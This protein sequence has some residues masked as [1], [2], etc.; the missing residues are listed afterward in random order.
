M[1][2][3]GT[4]T[5]PIGQRDGDDRTEHDSSGSTQASSRIW[6]IALILTPLL[7]YGCWR[8][9]FLD[10]DDRLFILDNPALKLDAP[11][12]ETF[13]R[14]IDYLYMPLTYLSLRIDHAISA[15]FAG[16]M[17]AA[18]AWAMEIRFGNVLIHAGAALMAWWLMRGLKASAPLA[19][20]VA[21][22]F[23]LHPTVCHS[24]CWP[25]QRKTVLAAF[26]GYAA[27]GVYVRGTSARHVA[28]AALLHALAVLS[29][30]SA[31]GLLPAI[32]VWE[33]LGRPDLDAS[34]PRLP[35]LS[36]GFADW[37]GAALR[38]SPWVLTLAAAYWNQITV[39]RSMSTSAPPLV[40]GSYWTV[41]L[42]DVP[43][44]LRYVVNF[45]WPLHLSAEYGLPAVVSVF[46]TEL[47]L[48]GLALGAFVALTFFLARPERRRMMVFAWLAFLALLFPALNFFGKYNL[49]ADCHAYLSTPAFWLVVGLAAEGAAARMP[50]LIPQP[51]RAAA[52]AVAVLSVA[53]AAGSASRSTV[54]AS[55]EAMYTDCAQ[56][57]PRCAVGRM[58]L[59][60]I[61]H[62]KAQRQFAA[63]DL[64]GEKISRRRELEELEACVNGYLFE[65]CRMTDVYLSLARAYYEYGR[66]DEAS[67]NLQL[68]RNSWQGMDRNQGSL[69]MWLAG[70]INADKGDFIKAYRDFDGA[71]ALAPQN[72]FIWLDRTKA[73]LALGEKFQKSGENESAK[74]SFEAA[75]AGLQSV[76]KSDPVYADL[77]N[78]LKQAP[79]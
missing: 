1:S 79:H 32:A 59:G 69:A 73:L 62:A 33:L 40:G 31:F 35:L 64:N 68:A 67:A 78:M 20:F 58:I 76:P 25:I 77:E 72:T 57:E 9:P 19:G 21:A 37:R 48:C 18:D 49:M 46:D 53:L 13:R 75:Q 29:K 12:S 4:V 52:A 14:D 51:R 26:F 30:A 15:L 11:W 45:I 54:F 38:L 5:K 17:D 42:T 60:N 43:V 3:N 65:R 55:A 56:K 7:I 39:V 71:L 28:G 16:T 63:G 41:A 61:M 47:W 44:L 8:A 66:M 74:N 2:L 6:L 50:G 23:A 24:V 27:L 22:A 36:R 70:L 10:F 34:K